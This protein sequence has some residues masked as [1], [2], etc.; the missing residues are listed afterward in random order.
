MSIPSPP[1]RGSRGI[2]PISDEESCPEESAAA[3]DE[4]SL[5]KPDEG[6]L[7]FKRGATGLRTIYIRRSVRSNE[8]SNHSVPLPLSAKAPHP[9]SAGGRFTEVHGLPSGTESHCFIV[10]APQHL[11]GR[12][13][14]QMQ[15]FQKSEELFILLVDAQYFG[16]FRRAQ[17]R[18]QYRSLPPQLGDSSSQR[19]AVRAGLFVAEAL[20]EQSFHFRRDGMFH[21]LRLVVSLRPGQSDHF[22]QQHL[23][24]LMPQRKVFGKLS[25]FL[26]QV[27]PPAALNAHVSVAHH[28]FQ[29]G[30]HRGRCNFQFLGEPRADGRVVLFQHLP[31][32]L[33]I[34]FLRYACLFSPQRHSYFSSVL[35]SRFSL[36]PAASWSTRRLMPSNTL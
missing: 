32:R 4:G 8:Q 30:G 16:R 9:D 33:Q 2:S 26:R 3:D 21:S 29:G 20:Q 7:L 6:F 13:R 5:F 28:A 22:R 10:L 15:P 17:I 11:Y 31:D 18:Q 27:D 25:A 14:T 34:I 36:R 23:G 35:C 1:R 12:R 19:N 24:E